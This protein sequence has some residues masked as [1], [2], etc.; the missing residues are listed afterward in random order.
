MYSTHTCHSVPLTLGPS[1]SREGKNRETREKELARTVL[2]TG[3]KSSGRRQN[4]IST[5]KMNR[6]DAGNTTFHPVML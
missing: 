2:F 1:L 4:V 3:R 6:A 5:K